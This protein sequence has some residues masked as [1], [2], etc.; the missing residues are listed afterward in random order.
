MARANELT[1]IV[2]RKGCGKSTVARAEVSERHRRIYIDPMFEHGAE[3]VVVRDYRSLV[4]YLRQRRHLSYS[5]VL[6]TMSESEMIAA[7]ALA[8]WGEPTNPPLPGVTYI[9]DECDRLCSPTSVPEPLKNL[10]NYGR[11]FQASAVFIARRAKRM[12]TD[13]RALA[14]RMLIGETFEP[15][16]VDA[17]AEFI[18]G[19]LAERV[20]ATR[21][22]AFIEWPET[23]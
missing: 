20:R 23:A 11:H 8:T 6:Q 7:I 22:P 9:V 5:V 18:G 3:G 13:F 19:E 17:L 2:G 15:G 1:L 10:A 4:A 14:D 16:D 21:A 12:P